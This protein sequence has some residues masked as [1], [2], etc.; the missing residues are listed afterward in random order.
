MRNFEKKTVKIV[1]ASGDLPPNPC[2][3]SEA[4]LKT[5]LKWLQNPHCYSWS[6]QNPH[7]YSC[8]LL[9]LCRVCF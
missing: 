4:R 7:C 9:Q 5:R 2:L 1:S 3:P 8:L 6:P